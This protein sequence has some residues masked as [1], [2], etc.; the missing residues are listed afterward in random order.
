MPGLPSAL[1]KHRTLVFDTYERRLP[2][3]SPNNT[4]VTVDNTITAQN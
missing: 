1:G 2:Y 3:L 4:P